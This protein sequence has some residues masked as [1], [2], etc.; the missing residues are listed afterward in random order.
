MGYRYLRSTGASQAPIAV[1]T[2]MVPSYFLG[3]A[4]INLYS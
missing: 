3:D 4:E 1:K 2:S